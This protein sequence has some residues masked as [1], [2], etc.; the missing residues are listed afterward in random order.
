MK[1]FKLILQNEYDVEA[2]N[3]DDAID[4]LADRFDRENTTVGSEFWES[5]EV[6]ELTNK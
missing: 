1:K 3:E 4:T 5:I 6:V 2:E